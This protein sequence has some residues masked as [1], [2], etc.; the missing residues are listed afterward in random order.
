LHGDN[1]YGFLRLDMAEYQEK[2]RVSQLLGAPQGYVGYGDSAQLTE[3][4]SSRPRMF[5]LFDEIEKAHP[6]VIRALMNAMDAGRLSSSQSQNGSHEIDC[7][8]AIFYFT[9]NLAAGAIIQE[10][11][12]RRASEYFDDIDAVCQRQLQRAGMAQELVG[13][14]STFLMFGLLSGRARA[15][16]AA[17]AVLRVGD[18]YGLSVSR[19]EPSVISTV[20]QEAGDGSLGARPDEYLIDELLGAAFARARSDG[21]EDGVVV[22]GP[23]FRCAT[24][25][26]DLDT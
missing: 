18:E 13:R 23:P 24:F 9:S 21:L 20:L 7:R 14:I 4:L 8:Y 26:E 2:H 16:I 6:D 10:V 1:A 17:L 15:E 5:V 11:T 22:T 19:V 25:A 12:T 3:A